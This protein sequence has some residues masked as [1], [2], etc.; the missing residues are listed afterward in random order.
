[1]NKDKFEQIIRDAG[2]RPEVRQPLRDLE[3]YVAD[4]F[5]L[6]PHNAWRRFGVEADEFPSGM[7]V[8]LWMLSK[9]EGQLG[10][11]RPMFFDTFHNPELDAP[12]KKQARIAAAIADADKH[13]EDRKKRTH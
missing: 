4:G 1:M 12:S 13:L 2:L 9:R 11:G 3:V 7:Y 6:M 10:G 5:S 8:T